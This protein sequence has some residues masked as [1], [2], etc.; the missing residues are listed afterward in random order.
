MH[1]H[2]AAWW[3]NLRD[4]ALLTISGHVYQQETVE[5]GEPLL[6]NVLITVQDVEGSAHTAITNHHGFY[7]VSAPAGMLSITASKPGYASRVLALD[8]STNT[9]VTFHLSPQ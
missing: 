1:R 9:I 3:R 6:V 2:N 5:L 7:T 8:L 4:A